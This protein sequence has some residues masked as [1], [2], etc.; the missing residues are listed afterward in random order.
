MV[1]GM[2]GAVRTFAVGSGMSRAEQAKLTPRRL[3][4]LTVVYDWTDM[5]VVASIEDGYIHT[6]RERQQVGHRTAV[7]A[8]SLTS[9]PS[10]SCNVSV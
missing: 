7:V 4:G 3:R 10:P 1:A 2:G 8:V 9:D 6:I 5:G